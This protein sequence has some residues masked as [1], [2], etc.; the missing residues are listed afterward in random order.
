MQWSETLVVT[1]FDTAS[2]RSERLWSYT[3]AAARRWRSGYCIVPI[4]DPSTPGSA[5]CGTAEWPHYLASAPL[6]AAV[7]LDAEHDRL[8]WVAAD[9]APLRRQPDLMRLP[10]EST[11]QLI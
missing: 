7:M 9:E 11:I 6:D 4:T 10:L 1:P 5:E 2:H 3:A 8:E